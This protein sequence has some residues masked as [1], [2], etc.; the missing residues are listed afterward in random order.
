MWKKINTFFKMKVMLA[1][2]PLSTFL[3]MSPIQGVAC[4]FQLNLK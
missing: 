3:K 2:L 4:T 1:F